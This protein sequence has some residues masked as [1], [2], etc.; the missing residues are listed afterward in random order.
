[1]RPGRQAVYTRGKLLKPSCA[2]NMDLDVRG[3][4]W[5][6]PDEK[7]A[8]MQGKSSSVLRDEIADLIVDAKAESGLD[9]VCC[10]EMPHRNE[11]K[12]EEV[13]SG[14]LHNPIDTAGYKLISL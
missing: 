6:V 8:Q 9:V 13:H 1:M 5:H 10:A 7:V 3:R 14:G 12:M 11:K 2:A 4:R